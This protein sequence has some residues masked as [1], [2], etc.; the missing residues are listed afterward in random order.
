MY[1]CDGEWGGTAFACIHTMYTCIESKSYNVLYTY[2]SQVCSVYMYIYMYMYASMKLKPTHRG[3]QGPKRMYDILCDML[4]SGVQAHTTIP[5][6]INHT[7][8]AVI[9][10]FAVR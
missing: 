4:K 3:C 1:A 2:L 8:L 10:S 5:D 6:S 7:A 9:A